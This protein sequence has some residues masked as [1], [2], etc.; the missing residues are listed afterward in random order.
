MT[1]LKQNIVFISLAFLIAGCGSVETKSTS[2][3]QPISDYYSGYFFDATISG[4]NVVPI[5]NKASK[6]KIKKY[7]RAN[8]VRWQLDGKVVGGISVKVKENSRSK[9]T[10]GKLSN[11]PQITFIPLEG[12][13]KSTYKALSKSKDVLVDGSGVV[14]VKNYATDNRLPSGAYILRVKVR[15]TQN[16]DRKEVYIEVK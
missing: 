2:G 16:W 8:D 15:G 13:K 5:Q 3:A 4:L 14:S 7:I 1:I 6:T 11:R 10:I 9:S 12:Q